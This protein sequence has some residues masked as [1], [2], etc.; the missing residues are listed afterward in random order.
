MLMHTNGNWHKHR[1]RMYAHMKMPNSKTDRTPKLVCGSTEDVAMMVAA[2]GSDFAL[3]SSAWN[4]FN[5]AMPSGTK[6]RPIGRSSGRAEW[7][8]RLLPR[9]SAL[10]PQDGHVT[11]RSTR[12]NGVV[13]VKVGG[14][15]GQDHY[16]YN[17][18]CH[19][20]TSDPMVDSFSIHRS[21]SKGSPEW[22][23]GDIGKG[24]VKVSL[25]NSEACER[26]AR[27]EL[28]VLE[29]AIS[30][31]QSLL[32]TAIE[33]AQKAHGLPDGPK[34]EAALAVEEKE[35]ALHAAKAAAAGLMEARKTMKRREWK[36]Q[37]ATAKRAVAEADA[38]LQT[39]R[40]GFDH[41]HWLTEKM[42]DLNAGYI[43]DIKAK[44]KSHEARAADCRSLIAY[45]ASYSALDELT[46]HAAALATALATSTVIAMSAA[47]AGEMMLERGRNP[48]RAKKEAP[49]GY[50]IGYSGALGEGGGGLLAVGGFAATASVVSGGC[51]GCRSDLH[52]GGDGDGGGGG[53]GGDGGGDG[54]DGGGDGGDGGG[55][56]GCRD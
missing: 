51:G 4:N 28:E 7:K 22:L 38:G 1:A 31:L 2:G 40:A 15:N 13:N 8:V 10:P 42:N 24:E 44:L 20:I 52:F 11:Q 16:E 27:R 9:A 29:R 6:A 32:A 3:V 21:S 48:T 5:P 49:D 35:T 43:E 50:G 39:A 30:D 12:Q 19:G 56:G 54:G 18:V 34:K 45:N 33:G 36:A 26:N 14:T 17:G 37:M 47:T 53:G 23:H 46:E 55:C 41:V 25:P